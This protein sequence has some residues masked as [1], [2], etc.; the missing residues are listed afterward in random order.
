MSELRTARLTLRPFEPDDEGAVLAYRNDPAVARFQ[1]WPLPFTRALFLKLLGPAADPSEG[2]WVS[3]CICDSTGVC[4]DIALRLH[5]QQGEVGISLAVS[6]QGRGYA[7][8]ALTAITG[9]AFGELGLHR[10][11]AGVDPKNHGSTQLFA[12]HR[13]RHE[14]TSLQSYNHRGQWAD[15]ATYA[16]LAKEWNAREQ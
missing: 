15:E 6:A 11:H 12:R 7:S 9:H 10:L 2:A 8:E 1:G 3:R 13:W 4:G 16:L 5:D 14:G